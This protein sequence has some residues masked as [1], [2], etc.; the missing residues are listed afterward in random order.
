MASLNTRGNKSSKVNVDDEVQ[1]L[2]GLGIDVS[3]TNIKELKANI[4][5]INSN[6]SSL[7]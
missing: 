3:N 7:I 6:F 2:L 1:K 4:N 5:E